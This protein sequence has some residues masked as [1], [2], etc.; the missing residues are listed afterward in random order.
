ML[1]ILPQR[2]VLKD[3]QASFSLLPLVY[4]FSLSPLLQNHPPRFLPRLG[5]DL[6]PI[7]YSEIIRPSFFFSSSHPE[8]PL[9][10]HFAHQRSSHFLLISK[11]I[12]D[13]PCLLLPA[14]DT[15]VFPLG[16][17]TLP[18]ERLKLKRTENSLLQ[19]Q[20]SPNGLFSQC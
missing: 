18:R 9:F 12:S 6:S 2:T 7:N 19:L 5:V 4:I 16:P 17:P 1:M 3:C 15:A 13:R 10:S 14:G 8:T 11:E 20:D